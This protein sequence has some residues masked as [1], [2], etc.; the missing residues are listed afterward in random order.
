[1]AATES[2][3]DRDRFCGGK[4]RSVEGGNCTRPAG[5]GTSHV[6][7]GRCKLHGGGSPSHVA[8]AER[9]QVE[10]LAARYSTPRDV[11]PLQ[12]VLEQYHRLAGQIAW[13]EAKVNEL[14]EGE[15]FWGV[16]SETDKPGGP[17]GGG[18]LETKR[19]AG[20]NA[21]VEQLDRVGVQFAKL[22]VEII[23]IGLETAGDAMASKFAARLQ[24]MLAELVAE[25][26]ALAV[27]RPGVD[28]SA[29]FQARMVAKVAAF[30]GVK[31]DA[32]EGA[33]A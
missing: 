32:I 6:G 14:P 9:I 24:V 18:G 30:A 5:W 33:A 21:Y 26:A 15:L 31:P 17:D 11:H 8:A 13:L 3:A 29:Q 22:G 25:L 27:E 2:G 12:G 7:I 16:E 4:K 19:K 1:M 23:R 20:P 28:L 10:Q